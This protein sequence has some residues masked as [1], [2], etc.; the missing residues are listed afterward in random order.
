MG[1]GGLFKEGG[2]KLD[3]PLGYPPFTHR[4]LCLVLYPQ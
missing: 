3:S 4:K 1:G 2:V